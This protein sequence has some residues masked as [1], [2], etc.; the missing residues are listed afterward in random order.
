M[1]YSKIAHALHSEINEWG[2]LLDSYENIEAPAEQ[3]NQDGK[4]M[5]TF[6]KQLGITQRFQ[7]RMLSD[8]LIAFKSI[9]NAEN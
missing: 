4:D 8:L 7:V 1:N 3:L 9:N 6:M 2:D 5:Q